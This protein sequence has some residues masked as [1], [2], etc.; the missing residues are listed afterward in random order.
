MGDDP[1]EFLINLAMTGINT[2]IPDH[3]I[4]LFGDV[5][6][7]P[8][9]KLHNR[10]GF[11]DILFIFM[12][13]VMESDKVTIIVVNPG[14]GDDGASE[15]TS[16][17][18]YNCFWITFVWL[19]MHIEA[20]FMLP[21]A[22][23]FHLFK[24]RANLCFHFVEKSSTKGI[25]E[26]GIV[27]VMDITPET[28]ITISALGNKTVDM[29]VPFEISAEGVEDHDEAG[30][31]VHRFILLEKH[32]GNNT[33]YGMKKAVK[34]RTVIEEKVPELG[35]NGKNAMAVD[36]IDQFK[37][38]RGS[39]LHGIKVAAGGT[40]AAVAAERDEFQLSTVGTAV[41]GT[42]RGRITAADHFIHVFNHRSTW[43]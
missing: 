27:K 1:V 13:V 43:M 30:S 14:C 31:E 18:F 11:F 19:G 17:V 5:P 25:A 8:F 26:E 21:V 2:A 35:I 12:T 29:R 23:G 38:H 37:G 28:S 42:A 41:H 36:N 22:L 34:E 9:Y 3:L 10:D 20:I 7:E 6:D 33:I 15:I 40:K 4:M 32:A 16:D 39:A 24:G